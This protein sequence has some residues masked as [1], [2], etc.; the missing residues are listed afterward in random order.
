MTPK[1]YLEVLQLCERAYYED[2]DVA[3]HLREFEDSTHVLLINEDDRLVSHALW[4]E[5]WLV[6]NTG[7]VRSAYV[8][9]VATDPEQQ[10]QGHASTVMRALGT[11]IAEFDIGALSPSD[12]AF[13][14]RFGWESW[15]GPLFEEREDGSARPSLDEVVMVLKQAGRP[16][17]DIDGALTAPWRPG[18]IW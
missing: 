12:P 14:A 15:R 8:E 1:R 4:V 10:R 16:S 9:L 13:Y 11:A 6:H 7:R 2:D 3:D 5:R 18:E 17:L